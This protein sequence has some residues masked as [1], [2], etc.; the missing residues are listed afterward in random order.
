MIDVKTYRPTRAEFISD[1]AVHAVGVAAALGA[2]PV[3][4]WFSIDRH[5]DA[6]MIAAVVVYGVA[7]LGMLICSAVYNVSGQHRLTGILKRLDH[8][9]I[10]LKIAGTFTP[11][12]A[13]TGGA[14]IA[15]LATIWAVALGGSSLKIMA[16]NSLRWLGLS[17]YLGL[18]WVGVFFG[19]EVFAA[20]TPGAF[21]A[22]VVGGLVYTVGVIFFLW[23]ALPFHTAIWHLFVLIATGFLYT[24][25]CLQ[26]AS[27]DGSQFIV[28]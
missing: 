13:M 21:A 9:A 14:G 28:G 24:A 23:E 22:V 10:F 8:S 11:L 5:D 15:Y 26:V 25:V 12:V 27:F 3:L 20:L 19:G 4:I 2:V 17:L 7:L 18:A 16:P 1:A 6:R